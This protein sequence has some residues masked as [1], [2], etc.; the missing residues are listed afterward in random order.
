MA[1]TAP[2]DQYGE[3]LGLDKLLS[4][5]H[6]RSAAAG[7][8]VHDEMLFIQFHQI[9]ELWFKQVLFELDDIQSRL[10]Q[11]T[12]DEHEMQPILIHLGRV[13][14]IFKQMDQMIDVLETMPPQSFVDFREHLGTASGFQSLQFRLIEIRL[15]LPRTKRLPVF[16]GQ[17]DENLAAESRALIQRAERQPTLFDLL[18]QWLS[19]TPFVHLGNYEFWNEYR[20]A[21]HGMLDAKADAARRTLTG[22]VLTRELE[23]ISRGKEK[24]EGNLRRGPSMQWPRRKGGGGCRGRR[25][26]RLCSSR[27]T[28]M[29]RYCRPRTRCWPA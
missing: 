12:V 15:G 24:F 4:A 20:A 8:P 22:D 29:N 28:A 7:E 5:Q 10:A 13:V 19:R 1:N 16:H 26:K 3:Y 27:S 11:K 9:Y 2:W 21:V 14:E 25:C 17:F 6:P 18:D 23:A